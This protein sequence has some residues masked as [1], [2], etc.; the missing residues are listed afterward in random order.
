MFHEP[1]KIAVLMPLLI[2]LNNLKRIKAANLNETFAA[3]IFK[4]A[5]VDLINGADLRKVALVTTAKS[6]AAVQLGAIDAEV[7]RN[8]GLSQ[9]QTIGILT[10]SFDSVA[11]AI[12]EDLRRELRTH[13]SQNFETNA[14]APNFVEKLARQPRAGATKKGAPRL[15]FEQ[16]EN[17]A[18]H[19]FSVAIYAVLLASFFQTNIETPFLTALVH[20]FHNA[21]L[22]DSGFAGEEMLGE[23]LPEVFQNLREQVLR[24]IPES[25][26]EKARNGFRLTETADSPESKTFHAADVIDRVLQV[27]H[28]A[29]I[30]KFTMRYA[31]EEMELVH[32]GAIQTFHHEVLRDAGII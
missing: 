31:L 9:N 3:E 21:D 1:Q 17:H 7:L 14:D 6:I 19:C 28:H 25:M 15:V 4:R 27:R 29:E 18:E 24:E 23:F 30:N 8:A 16:T 13:L 32:E 26:R 22:P 2:E 20:H 12:D 5:W 11:S 10:R